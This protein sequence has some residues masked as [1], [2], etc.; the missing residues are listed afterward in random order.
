MTSPLRDADVVT[1][2]DGPSVRSL[3]FA[4]STMLDDVAVY[5]RATVKA[6]FQDVRHADLPNGLHMEYAVH[7]A[8]DDAP[9]KILLLMGL[10]GEKETWTPL[11]ATLLDQSTHHHAQY[12]IVT[13][14]N[15][16]VGGSSK[17]F[18]RYTTALLADDARLLLEHLGWTNVHVVGVS[19]GGMVAQELAYAA[20]H[21]VRSLALIVSSPGH[22]TG[23][24]P[25]ITQFATYLTMAKFGFARSMHD[26]VDTMMS[27][28]YPKHYLAETASDGRTMHEMLHQFHLE[29]LDGVTFNLAGVHGQHAAVFGHNMSPA[30][31]EAVRAHG[32]PIL[33]VG[34]AHDW[35]LHPKNADYLFM[36]LEGPHTRKVVFDTSGH[37]VQNQMRREVAAAL[38]DHFAVEP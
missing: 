26:I 23:A 37:C 3:H 2:D 15:R 11:L 1:D 30:R 18:V 22:T 19:M 16:G 8:G 33:V 20:P 27:T 14:D 38:H 4:A 25:G 13:L 12:Q 21:L 7:G 34:A 36:H 31:L 29:L 32:F 24:F 35:I 28:L 6:L 10:M 9:H 17:P 5:T